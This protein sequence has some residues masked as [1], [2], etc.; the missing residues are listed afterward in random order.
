[1]ASIY[2]IS[3]KSIKFIKLN[4]DKETYGFTANLYVDNKKVALCSCLE[5]AKAPTIDWVKDI[6]LSD[7][8]NKYVTIY[9][10]DNFGFTDIDTLIN[11]LLELNDIEKEFKSAIKKGAKAL[12]SFY[13]SRRGRCI[14]GFTQWN[15]VIEEKFKAKYN[16]K[17]FKV[18][19]SLDD[20]ILQ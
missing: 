20:F 18:Y 5:H 8:L 3:L 4:S 6:D 11:H 2:G 16:P 15:D 12:I 9:K 7:R 10:N 17:E 14:V 1:M 19:T 13:S